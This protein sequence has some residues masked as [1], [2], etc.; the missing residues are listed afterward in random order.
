MLNLEYLKWS[1][2]CTPQHNVNVAYTRLWPGR[3][4]ITWADFAR[5]RA[6]SSSRA[7]GAPVVHGH[8]VPP[9]GAVRGVRESDAD[10]RRR[11]ERYEGQA[12]FD[13]LAEVPTTWDETRFLAGEPGEYVVLARRKGD[14]WYLGGITNWTPRKIDVPL[15]ALG[16]GRFD[17]KLYVDG[18]L[19]ESQPNA[20]LTR[21]ETVDASRPLRVSLAPG[22][23]F[24]GVLLK[25]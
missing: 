15:D 23:G 25:K 5:S 8:A 22:G 12:G 17:A 11:A 6:R 13:F 9:P 21:R 10:G 2:R 20:V 3:W 1:D 24:V 4:I 16:D 7:I 19:D 14:A 18:S